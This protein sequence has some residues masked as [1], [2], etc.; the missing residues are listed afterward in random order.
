LADAGSDHMGYHAQASRPA[1]A[2]PSQAS[3]KREI[4]K[5]GEPILVTEDD[6]TKNRAIIVRSPCYDSPLGKY[7][8]EADEV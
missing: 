5:V 1:E 8:V 7:T 3:G 6:G 2:T 4:P